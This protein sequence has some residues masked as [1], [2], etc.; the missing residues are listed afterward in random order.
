VSDWIVVRLGI[1]ALAGLAVGLE[2][3]WSGKAHGPQARFAGL[4]TFFLLGTL[5]GVAGWLA[6]SQTVGPVALG[7]ALVTAATALVVIAYF[8]AGRRG[9]E[10][11]E[12]TTEVAALVVI[13][14]G[15]LAGLGYVVIA[16]GASAIMVLALSE[17]DRLRAAVARIGAEELR[18]GFQFAVLALVI[19]PLLPDRTFGPLGGINPR[20]LWIVVLLFSGLNFAGYLARKA[21]GAARGYGMAGLLGGLVSSTAVS[22]QFSRLSRDEPSLGRG[23]AIGVIA[24]CTVLLPRVVVL[25]LALNFRVAYALLPLLAPPFVVGAA[26]TAVALWRERGGSASESDVGNQSPLRV[27]SAIRMALAFQAA[28]TGIALVRATVGNPG[29]L[30]SAALL[31]LTDMDALTLSMN[32]L[33]TS[34]DVVTLAAHAIAI[35]VI[36]NSLLKLGVVVTLGTGEF[37]R[38]AALGLALLTVIS[39]I[40]LAVFW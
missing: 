9:G 10:A 37:R 13:A 39:G 21:A 17:K 38:W 24:A 12:A 31:G 35:G 4:R 20:Q 28:L 7:V 6:S 25:S 1:A 16:S 36:A 18:A 3:E 11:I 19:L 33:G 34:S 14:L 23:L 5:S 29:I 15:A 26:I 40:A 30:V 2:R 22:L 8:L 27:W 32:R